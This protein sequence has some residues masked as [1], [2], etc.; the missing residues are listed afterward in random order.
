[1]ARPTPTS[2]GRLRA[3][4]R[5]RD[6]PGRY[7][8]FA[9]S[10]PFRRIADVASGR[11]LEPDPDRGSVDRGD[12]H[13]LKLFKL[14]NGA[15]YHDVTQIVEKIAR[16]LFVGAERPEIVLFVERPKRSGF[17]AQISAGGKAASLA[18]DDDNSNTTVAPDLIEQHVQLHAHPHVDRI[19][20]L[21][22]R[23]RH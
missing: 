4:P 11:E 9:K 18:G 8:D 12:G 15:L 23:Q 22:P 17:G 7:C 10:G 3:P 1:M 19:E 20:S 2:F 14:T 6:K 13:R 21:R 16:Q 5:L